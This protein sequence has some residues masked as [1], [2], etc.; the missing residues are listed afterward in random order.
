MSDLVSWAMPLIRNLIPA[1]SDNLEFG[2]IGQDLFSFRKDFGGL[3]ADRR[4]W[5]LDFEKNSSADDIG[6]SLQF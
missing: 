1:I 4:L 2:M 5:Y 3:K 6:G